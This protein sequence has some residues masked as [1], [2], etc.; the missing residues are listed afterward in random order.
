[1]KI[2]GEKI[3]APGIAYAVI[4]RPDN[5]I[6]F[7][8]HSVL[9]Y[10]EF[11]ALCPQPEPPWV[12]HRSGKR[13]QDYDDKRYIKARGEWATKRQAWMVLKSLEGTPGLEWETINKGDP[14]TWG[15]YVK[16]L[17]ECG[18]SPLEISR[19]LDSVYDSCGLNQKK[20]DEAMERFLSGE[21]EKALAESSREEEA[22]ATSSSEPVSAST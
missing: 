18:F 10:D 6:I 1:M 8:C 9:S 3:H 14:E 19:I 16:E 21:R 12:R 7:T 5:D 22:S 11:D 15:N 17:E 13:Q 4:P 2:N 20:I